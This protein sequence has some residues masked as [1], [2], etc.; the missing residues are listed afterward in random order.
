M[1]AIAY[2]RVSTQG[3]VDEGVS[4]AAQEAKLRAW[5]ELNGAASVRVFRDEGIGGGRADN[6]PGLQAALAAVEEGDAL[7][8]YSLSRLSRS[9]KDTLTLAEALQKRGADLVSLSEKIDTTSASG[10]MVFRLLA[11]LGEF[12]RDQVSE[13]TRT[14]L[15][16]KRTRHEKTGGGVPFGYSSRA[17]RLTPKAREQATISDIIGR[18]QRGES[19]RAICAALEASGVRRKGG[20][21]AWHPEAVKR[22]L[23]RGA[24][25]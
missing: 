16:Y 23:A 17:G 9:T 11:V 4:L 13:R 10:K 3:Q 8:C 18:R 7:V 19:L 21:A 15:A 24:A 2:V 6:R 20:A 12:E 22:I 25:A 14:A 5:A 1:K